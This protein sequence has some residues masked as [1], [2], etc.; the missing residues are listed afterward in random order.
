MF[1]AILQIMIETDILKDFNDYYII[2]E[3]E[4]IMVV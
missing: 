1:K 4:F 3:D 2:I